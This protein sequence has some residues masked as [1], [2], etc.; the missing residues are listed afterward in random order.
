MGSGKLH[1][2]VVGKYS[3]FENDCILYLLLFYTLSQFYLDCIHIHK[4]AYF[5]WGC[6]LHYMVAVVGHQANK[7]PHVNFPF[8]LTV[9]STLMVHPLSHQRTVM[10]V[11]IHFYKCHFLNLS[12]HNYITREIREL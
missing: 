8:S 7:A 11:S 10:K 5:I 9:Q 2:T 12:C 4:C 6:T 1:I 3:S